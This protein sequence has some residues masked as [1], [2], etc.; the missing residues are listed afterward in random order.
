MGDA[1]AVGSIENDVALAAPT[2]AA[3]VD[4]TGEVAQLRCGALELEAKW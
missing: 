1:E 3:T 4:S 2:H